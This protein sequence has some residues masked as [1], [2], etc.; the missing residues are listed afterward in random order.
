M[1]DALCWL[2]DGHGGQWEGKNSPS[3]PARSVDVLATQYSVDSIAS[4]LFL[5]LFP[6]M[7]PGPKP[8]S[9]KELFLPNKST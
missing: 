9:V 2:Q 4:A 3:V 6:K 8:L 1:H 5:E 7:E